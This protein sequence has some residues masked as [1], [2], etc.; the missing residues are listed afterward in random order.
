LPVIVQLV[1][2][3]FARFYYD[4]PGSLISQMPLTGQ[5]PNKMANFADF[6]NTDTKSFQHVSKEKNFIHCQ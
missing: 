4:H 5:V 6:K 1:L 2:E 3:V